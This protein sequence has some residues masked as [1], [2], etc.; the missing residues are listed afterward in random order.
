MMIADQ[1]GFQGEN[2]RC[3]KHGGWLHDCGKIGV[4][5]ELLNSSGRL[6]DSQFNTI[7]KHPEWGARVARQARLPQIVIN[8]ILHHHERY[9]GEG[10]PHG[11]KGGSIPVEARIVAIADVFDALTT[12][13][14]YRDPLARDE[15]LAL[16]D[17]MSGHHLDPEL[18][19]IFRFA[20]AGS[21]RVGTMQAAAG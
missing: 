21:G 10:Y 13:R 5:D 17:A 14:S 2:M 15:A 12:Q 19:G 9:D 18:M 7:R 11:L 1:L 3:I 4:P 16:M 6:N 8:I 20:I